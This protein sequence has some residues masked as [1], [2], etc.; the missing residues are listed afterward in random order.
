MSYEPSKSNNSSSN[1]RLKE[2][3]LA[4]PG[5]GKILLGDNKRL[6]KECNTLKKSL[7]LTQDELESLR[8]KNHELD[9]ENSLLNYRLGNALLPETLKFVSSALGAGL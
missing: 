5:V 4:H 8:C 2:E 6:R 3:D 7:K 9:K 1:L